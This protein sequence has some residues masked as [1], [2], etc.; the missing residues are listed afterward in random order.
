MGPTSKKTA[1]TRSGKL[2][3]L[4]KKYGSKAIEGLVRAQ[5]H[6]ALEHVQWCDE[7]DPHFTRFWL[8]FVYGGMTGRG[9]LDARTG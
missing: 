9:I 7:I 2:A 8:E 3:K 1:T 4:Q 6:H 5:P